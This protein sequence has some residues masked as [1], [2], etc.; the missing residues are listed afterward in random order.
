MRTVL[1]LITFLALFALV[2]MAVV[3]PIPGNEGAVDGVGPAAETRQ[4]VSPRDANDEAPSLASSTRI[5]RDAP[6]QTPSEVSSGSY[7]L[8]GRVVD[9]DDLPVSNALVQVHAGQRGMSLIEFVQRL[10]QPP[11]IFAE[12]RTDDAGRFAFEALP[13]ENVYVRVSSPHHATTDERR[14]WLEEER[15]GTREILVRLE[16]GHAAS[17]RLETEDGAPIPHAT[18]LL[19][20][21]IVTNDANG[22]PLPIEAVTDDA[23]RCAF[24]NLPTGVFTIA[25]PLAKTSGVSWNQALKIPDTADI[26]L[27]L[28][29]L[30]PLSGKVHDPEG[31]PIANA[32][33][34]LLVYAGPQRGGYLHLTSDIDGRFVHPGLPS[35]RISFGQV[36]REGFQSKRLDSRDWTRGHGEG[37]RPFAL[38]VTLQPATPLRGRLL[39][40]L[41]DEPIAFAMLRLV[42]DDSLLIPNT[43]TAASNGEGR[44]TLYPDWASKPRFD[45]DGEGESHPAFLEVTAEG[46]WSP[47]V[48]GLGELFQAGWKEKEAWGDLQFEADATLSSAERDF[49]VDRCARVRGRVVDLGGLGV[50][51]VTVR[52]VTE[53]GVPAGRRITTSGPDGR[54]VLEEVAPRIELV[55]EARSPLHAPGSMEPITLK[56]GETREDVIVPVSP[57]ST[58]TVRVYDAAGGAIQDAI[59]TLSNSGSRKDHRKA[60][61]TTGRV[62][63]DRITPGLHVLDVTHAGHLQR[64]IDRF[65]IE[66]G[67]VRELEVLLERTYPI[68]GIVVDDQEQP[69]ENARVFAA[70]GVHHPL[71]DS[72]GD[73]HFVLEQVPRG[74]YTLN[75]RHPSFLERQ[76][77]RVD[78]GTSNVRLVLER[79]G[80]IDGRVVDASGHPLKANVRTK[81]GNEWKSVES[82][83]HGNFT[84]VGLPEGSHELQIT[85][86]PSPP[87][88]RRRTLPNVATGTRQLEIVLESGLPIRGHL[89]SENGKNV[90]G[91]RVEIRTAAG[92]FCADCRTQ[93]DGTFATEGLEAGSYW[94]R[95]KDWVPAGV[96]WVRAVAGEENVQLHLLDLHVLTGHVVGPGGLALG[97]LRVEVLPQVGPHDASLLPRAHTLPD[98]RF[99]L[100]DLPPG[101]YDVRV[102]GT[103]KNEEG[104]ATTLRGIREGVSSSAA[105]IQV[106]L[107]EGS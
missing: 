1:V 24:T 69:I 44:F 67:T 19:L 106:R 51:G 12:A 49:R 92:A 6:G 36:Q 53:R 20:A 79:G 33:I 58:L 30:A 65:A 70:S 74:E 57:V 104:R 48:P 26:T 89:T 4:D 18:L 86:T 11:T 5:Q 66:E 34:T 95:I 88:P 37:E 31:L 94:V 68:R 2:W 41:T 8:L 38:D 85:P 28:P 35:E 90:S 75:A 42:S 56:P 29:R 15:E 102:G 46:Y 72:D 32:E 82:D 25:Y 7:G 62:R 76:P 87:W 64:R 16:A 14:V 10:T 105:D 97:G 23:G 39:D 99:V 96:A 71:A 63:F 61:D 91:R 98:G 40:S 93:R 81:V 13:R 47:R 43:S 84:L 3:E 50:P 21:E 17:L 107:H 80:T 55:L 60:T 78:A 59:V 103:V 52:P 27:T 9:T 101:V 100:R 73:G 77:M 54:F 22:L 45:A 83:A